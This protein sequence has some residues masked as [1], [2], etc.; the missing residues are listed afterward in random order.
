[1]DFNGFKVGSFSA[2]GAGVVSDKVSTSGESGSVRFIF[3][4]KNG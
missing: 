3:F 1:M 4:C 2:D